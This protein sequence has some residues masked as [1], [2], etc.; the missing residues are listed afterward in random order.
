MIVSSK[1]LR[2]IAADVRIVKERMVDGVDE[3]IW[4]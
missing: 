2:D 1:V 4:E 3:A